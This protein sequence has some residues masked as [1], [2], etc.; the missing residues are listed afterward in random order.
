MRCWRRACSAGLAV[1]SSAR[2]SA[3]RARYDALV[4]LGRWRPSLLPRRPRRGVTPTPPP[5]SGSWVRFLGSLPGPRVAPTSSRLRPRQRS[6][7]WFSCAHAGVGTICRRDVETLQRPLLAD[8]AVLN[9]P[10]AEDVVDRGQRE[11]I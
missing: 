9:C 3:L 1:S 2:W 4:P 7:R 8:P 10:I 11:E 6:R 5:L